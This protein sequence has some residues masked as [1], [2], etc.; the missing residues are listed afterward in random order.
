[1]H[2]LLTKLPLPVLQL[3]K[4]FVIIKQKLK[5]LKTQLAT[6]PKKRPKTQRSTR[7][8]STWDTLGLRQVASLPLL[9]LSLSPL[10]DACKLVEFL[11][12]SH[13][14]HTSRA[15]AKLHAS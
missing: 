2:V 12:L 6:S 7:I 4:K 11:Q 14:T 3:L 13:L 15:P 1:M 8:S 5:Q 10:L 9:C